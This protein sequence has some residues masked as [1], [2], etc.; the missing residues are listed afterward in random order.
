MKACGTG[1]VATAAVLIVVLQI[2]ALFPID[3]PTKGLAG[4]AL[5]L[6]RY[7]S[8]AKASSMAAAAVATVALQT[9]AGP[10]T[11][12]LVLTASGATMSAVRNVG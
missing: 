8:A 6:S 9:Y 10:T 4:R 7:A 12:R 1:L 2:N 11:T 3:P 5:A